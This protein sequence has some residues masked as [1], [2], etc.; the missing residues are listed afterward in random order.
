MSGNSEDERDVEG[1][2]LLGGR[3]GDNILDTTDDEG[4]EANKPSKPSGSGQQEKF[5]DW[6]WD[7]AMGHYVVGTIW[8]AVVGSSAMEVAHDTGSSFLALLVT[9]LLIGAASLFSYH[10]LMPD[11]VDWT[12]LLLY[13][14]LLA[15]PM[16]LLAG[17]MLY[18][19]DVMHLED[20]AV[21]ST[22]SSVGGWVVIATTLVFWPLPLLL[23]AW[24]CDLCF[25]C[26]NGGI[27]SRDN[28]GMAKA[29]GVGDNAFDDP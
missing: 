26:N 11:G 3:P 9:L 25:R 19:S 22:A 7:H 5:G 24:T 29:G 17:D 27:E 10:F 20:R 12:M 16:G 4:G 28:M 8:V 2:P 14:G 23:I 1:A 21:A 15:G 13:C 6:L 18:H